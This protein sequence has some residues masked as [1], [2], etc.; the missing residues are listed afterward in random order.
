MNSKPAFTVIELVFVIV[1]LGILAF[2]AIPKLMAT[3]DDAKISKMMMNIG[4]ITT[5]IASYAVSKGTV[6]SNIS[7]MSNLVNV[8]ESRKQATLDTAN[9][10]VTLKID[11]VDCIDVSIISSATNEDLNV[12][13]IPGGASNT[14]CHTLQNNIDVQMYQVPLRGMTVTH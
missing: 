4:I 10:K 5:E 14:I 9:K 8:L 12:S 11:G 2:V 6:D 1:I 13:L 7:V 3:R